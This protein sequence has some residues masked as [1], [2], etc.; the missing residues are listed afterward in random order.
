MLTLVFSSKNVVFSNFKT[1]FY[2]KQLPPRFFLK[3][4]HIM[5]RHAQ[6]IPIK[7]PGVSLMKP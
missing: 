6:E 4:V 3:V 2:Q 1:H 7:V 5:T